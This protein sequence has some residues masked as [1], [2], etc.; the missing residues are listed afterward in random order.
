MF[1]NLKK[2]SG[3]SLTAANG[4]DEEPPSLG[5]IIQDGE[6]LDDVIYLPNIPYQINSRFQLIEV[7]KWSIKSFDDCSITYGRFH[8]GIYQERAYSRKINETHKV[9]T[10]T[11]IEILVIDI[12]DGKYTATI[13]KMKI[14]DEN[15]GHPH[16]KIMVQVCDHYSPHLLN[17]TKTEALLYL[18]Y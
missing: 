13:H 10:H 14:E 18:I 11:N 3:Y 8:D 17:Y 2:R 6:Q 5:S 12:H 1:I 4:T 7:E 9:L 15:D 16:P